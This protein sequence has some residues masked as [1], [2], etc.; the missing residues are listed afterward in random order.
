MK[1]RRYYKGSVLLTTGIFFCIVI[2]CSTTKKQDFSFPG[3]IISLAPGITET[4]FALGLEEKVIGVTTYCHFPPE[5]KNIEKIGGYS[6]AN[7]EKIISLRPHLVVLSG[8]HEKQ[9]LYLD[10][11][12]VK[13][14]KI[15]NTTFEDICSS[16]AIIGKVCGV[17][18]RSDSLIRK[19]KEKL[20]KTAESIDGRPKVLLCI[21][22]DDP[23]TGQINTVFVAGIRTF[24]NDL[25]E[26]AGGANAFTESKVSY[27]RLSLE[28]I[29]A[30]APDIIIDIAP[31]MGN[32]DCK[33][34]VSDWLS[35]P[36]V[37]AVE[38]KKVFC[39]AKDYATIPGPRLML[40]LDDLKRIISGNIN[41][42]LPVDNC[43][44]RCSEEGFFSAAG[45]HKS[46]IIDRQHTMSEETFT[47][48][49]KRY[50][51]CRKT[52]KT[53]FRAAPWV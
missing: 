12:G 15:T 39:L 24:Y 21:G 5:T 53:I 27:P 14:L 19:F 10:R 33:K 40:L 13:T 45:S 20:I 29:M 44:G 31:A 25:I 6:D 42:E 3:R 1:R 4:L 8:E 34:L 28:G 18:D 2:G 17:S 50:M 22:R 51:Y 26:A 16:F 9:R 32:Y 23:G 35:L 41:T 37:P 11:F 43:I 30:V 7:L 38:N 52:E 48:F 47:L 36:H 49:I 46:G